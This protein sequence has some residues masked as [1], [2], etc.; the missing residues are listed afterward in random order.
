M[1]HHLGRDGGLLHNRS[2]R[3]DIALQNRDAALGM[4]GFFEGPDDRFIL[5][6]RMAHVVAHAVPRDRHGPAVQKASGEQSRHDRLDAAGPVEILDMMLS[7][8]AHA[9]DMR[10]LPAD[11]VHV[12][13]RQLQSGRMRD[14]RQVQRRVR[15]SA[16]RHIDSDGVLE[17]RFC[18]DFVGGDVLLDKRHDHAS[19]FLGEAFACGKHGRDRPVPRKRQPESFHHAIHRVR[20]EHSR[21]RAAGGTGGLFQLGKIFIRYAPGD[22]LSHAFKDGIQ[23]DLTS[24][25]ISGEHRPAAYDD[26]RDVQRRRG[27]SHAR[28]DLVAIRNQHQ[29]VERVR[30]DH[31]FDGIHDQ[32][33]ARQGELHSLMV[34]GDAV[35][36]ADHRKFKRKAAPG[37]DS[38]FCGFGNPAEMHMPGNQ[39]VERVHDSDPGALDLPLR[40]SARHQQRSVRRP[41]GSFFRHIASH[42]VHP[43]V[44]VRSHCGKPVPSDR[45][46]SPDEPGKDKY[47]IG[48]IDGQ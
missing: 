35:A 20:G 37:I 39:G 25:E 23:I 21:A 15:R 46:R 2:V 7:S 17:S 33:P 47:D 12:F 27:H 28:N 34:H 42:T 13:K 43:P 31:D 30:P 45:G 10:R 32:L 8:G 38:R 24:A 36:H 18:Q 16:E 41:L 29:G 1:F 40:V 4:V 14:R 26:R 48:D 19:G 9:A 6:G 3:R 5:N 44:S 22:P 11:L